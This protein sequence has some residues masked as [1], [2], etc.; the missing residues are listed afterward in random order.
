MSQNLDV[1]KQDRQKAE[2]VL[3]DS[4]NNAEALRTLALNELR[5][6]DS[7]DAVQHLEQALA[8]SLRT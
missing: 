7:D 5:L 3:A 2:D 4:P 6:K 8:A 1:V